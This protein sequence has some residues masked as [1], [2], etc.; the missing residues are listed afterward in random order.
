MRRQTRMVRGHVRLFE[1]CS[2]VLMRRSVCPSIQFGF[3]V[4]SDAPG[5]PA[6]AQLAG[7]DRMAAE[8]LARM[9]VAARAEMLGRDLLHGL[10]GL[11]GR[12]RCG[13]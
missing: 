4:A 2:T 7:E 8:Q 9:G 12:S 13:R 3:V 6:S 11:R 5:A 10:L 1:T